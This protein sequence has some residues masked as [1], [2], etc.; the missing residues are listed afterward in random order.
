M[1]LATSIIVGFLAAQSTVFADT[2]PEPESANERYVSNVIQLA[3]N[4]SRKKY[5]AVG[6]DAAEE[7]AH[8][9]LFV[10]RND[11]NNLI[12]ESDR[13]ALACYEKH[14]LKAACDKLY[15]GL[16][17]AAMFARSLAWG[18]GRYEGVDLGQAKPI[19]WLESFAQANVDVEGMPEDKSFSFPSTV[20]ISA[21]NNYAYY[22][23][24]QGKHQEA[25]PVFQKIIEID[26]SRTVAY[27]NLADSLWATGEKSKASQSYSQYVS[28]CEKMHF[29]GVP[30]R[31]RERYIAYAR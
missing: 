26:P 1:Q 17:C 12:Q 22:L 27:L 25:I 3:E 14:N 13:K 2:L 30:G 16:D 9:W 10:D 4:G 24:L 23:Q 20:Y 28:Q 29:D 8:V 5:E 19:V 11:L 21:V 18:N 6:T 31:V 15:C 7:I